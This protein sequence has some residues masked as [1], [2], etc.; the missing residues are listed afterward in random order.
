MSRIHVN[1]SRTQYHEDDVDSRQLGH[2][3]EALHATTNEM[4]ALCLVNYGFLREL[5]ELIRQVQHP[6]EA[7]QAHEG[8]NTIQQEE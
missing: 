1:P 6:Q 7:R 4:E 2:A 3:L 5:V 8:R